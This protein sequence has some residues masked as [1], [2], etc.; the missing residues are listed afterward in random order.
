[1]N[2]D[3]WIPVTHENCKHAVGPFYHGTKAHLAI[4]TLL[5]PGHPSNYEE[6][7]VSNNIYFSANLVVHPPNSL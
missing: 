6:G 5:L 4:G 7:R 3:Q 2:E 1:M